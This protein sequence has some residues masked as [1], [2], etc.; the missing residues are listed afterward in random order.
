MTKTANLSLSYLNETV[1]CLFFN[2]LYRYFHFIFRSNKVQNFKNE[3]FYKNQLSSNIEEL[4]KNSEPIDFSN[5]PLPEIPTKKTISGK[6]LSK[7]SLF[8]KSIN[9]QAKL[10]E[11]YSNEQTKKMHLQNSSTEKKPTYMFG[12][13]TAKR[14]A[15]KSRNSIFLN[16]S[17]WIQTKID[18][19]KQSNNS[20]QLS[21][22]S[23]VERMILRNE[24]RKANQQ[25]INAKENSVT[26]LKID[27]KLNAWP[28]SRPE[29]LPVKTTFSRYGPPPTPILS[30]PLAFQDQN[31]INQEKLKKQTQ[32]QLSV[33]DSDNKTMPALIGKGMVFSRSFEYDNRKYESS[34]EKFS[35]SFD[36]DLQSFPNGE[37]NK[38]I[39]SKF[40]D[41]PAFKNLTGVSPNY[42]S[43]KENHAVSSILL[44]SKFPKMI[45]GNKV[46]TK[47]DFDSAGIPYK[48][49]VKQSS[50]SRYSVKNEGNNLKYKSTAINNRLNSCDS[51]ARSGKTN[52]F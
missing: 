1:F 48:N 18:A 52:H 26:V 9:V 44:E 8:S 5:I 15:S 43:K 17:G 16:R 10:K 45:P 32:I 50:F 23:K 13:N 36:F 47:I 34:S 12:E 31:I 19:K 42:L 22:N 49:S 27:S 20:S 29:F 41:S 7:E 24:E 2:F 11:A 35:R 14:D 21:Q 30:P 6:S 40:G 37:K 28:N 39:L 25:V 4:N 38:N 3:N 46:N 51:G 33:T